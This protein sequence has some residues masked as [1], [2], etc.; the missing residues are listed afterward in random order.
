MTSLRRQN[1]TGPILSRFVTGVAYSPDGR[2]LVTAGA[3]G[4]VRWWDTSAGQETVTVPGRWLVATAGMWLYVW[5]AGP[6]GGQ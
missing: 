6:S 3:D 1:C 2:R 4:T 5:D